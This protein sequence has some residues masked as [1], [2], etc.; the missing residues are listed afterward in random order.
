MSEFGRWVLIAGYDMQARNPVY[1]RNRKGR[2]QAHKCARILRKMVRA[3]SNGDR[4][5]G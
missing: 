5:N 3:I 2:K 4:N 1:M